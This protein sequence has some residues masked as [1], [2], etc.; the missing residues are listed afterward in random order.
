MTFVSDRLFQIWDYNVSHSQML[1][2]SP[3]SPGDI[4][5]IDIIF[6]GIDYLGIPSKFQGIEVCEATAEEMAAIHSTVGQK[7]VKPRV[8]CLSTGGAR[9]FVAAVGF[10]ILENDLDLFESSLEY[11]LPDRPTKV[12]GEL[13]AHS[14][15][16]ETG[17]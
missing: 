8:Y 2:R 14:C 12:S 15:R 13:L 3:V 9:F 7:Y 5:N 1:L 10:K 17:S 16:I 6:W 4:R 11:F